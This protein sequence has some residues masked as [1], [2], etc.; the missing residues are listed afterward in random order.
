[1][2][3]CCSDCREAKNGDH[4]NEGGLYFVC[5][6]II[7]YMTLHSPEHPKGEKI[8]DEPGISFLLVEG[9]KHS[10]VGVF[11]AS[12]ALCLKWDLSLFLL[13]K[14]IVLFMSKGLTFAM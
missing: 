4:N 11:F 7:Q 3:A 14:G 5:L 10:V 8:E 6:P 1:M 12:V 9:I 2:E 13:S